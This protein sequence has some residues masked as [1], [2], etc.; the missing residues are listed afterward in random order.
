MENKT[1]KCQVCC[2]TGEKHFNGDLDCDAPG[3]TA[4]EDRAALNRY[5]KKLGPLTSFD[6]DWMVYQYASLD[7]KRKLQQELA[8]ILVAPASTGS[9]KIGDKMLHDALDIIDAQRARRHAREVAASLHAGVDRRA[10]VA[11]GPGI[12]HLESNV[13]EDDY[14][15]SYAHPAGFLE[16]IMPRSS[17]MQ[18]VTD[19]V[20]ESQP[21]AK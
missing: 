8:Q 18:A 10:S 11:C 19:A 9:T 14:S 7:V 13:S 15:F 6:R 16:R 4:A 21:C 1:V 2:D 17:D 20:K 3:C 5:V 12:E